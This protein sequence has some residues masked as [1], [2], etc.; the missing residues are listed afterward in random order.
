VVGS[1]RV[2][3]TFIAADCGNQP[4]TDNGQRQRFENAF[5][6]LVRCE[7]S[8]TG[9]ATNRYNCIAW[10][11]GETDWWYARILSDPVRRVIGIDQEYGDRDMRWDDDPNDVEYQDVNGNGY[12][13][14]GIDPWVDRNGNGIC[15]VCDI[16]EFYAKKKG[17]KPLAMG[18]MDAKAMYYS[19]Y[20]AAKRMYCA[21]GAGKWIMYE[22]K[23]GRLERIE[24]VWDQLNGSDYG[25]PK[26]FY[27]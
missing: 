6:N 27:K 8:I 2:R 9:E 25:Y 15:D 22:S 23:C 16:N 18:P 7:W 26:L 4:R 13:D 11:I 17:W 20:H 1:G 14:P 12:Y 10:S 24:H 21:C 3:Y 5:P 19:G